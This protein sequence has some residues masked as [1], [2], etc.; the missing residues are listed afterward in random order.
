MSTQ[1]ATAKVTQTSD[2]MQDRS[3][4]L[5]WVESQNLSFVLEGVNQVKF[6][7][8]PIPELKDPHDVL[9]NVRYTGICG[10]DVSTYYHV[11]PGLRLTFCVYRFITWHMAELANSSWKNPWFLDMNLPVSSARLARLYRR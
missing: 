2:L 10:S 9:L 7:D 11:E 8:R 1:T 5:T 4:I 6:E 3:G